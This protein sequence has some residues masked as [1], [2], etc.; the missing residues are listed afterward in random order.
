MKGQTGQTVGGKTLVLTGVHVNRSVDASTTLVCPD[1]P[2]KIVNR[3][4][5]SIE[6]AGRLSRGFTAPGTKTATTFA[7]SNWTKKSAQPS[8]GVLTMPLIRNSSM[9]LLTL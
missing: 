9:E 8:Q 7:C 3:K 4:I 5:P 6:T 2:S 1:R